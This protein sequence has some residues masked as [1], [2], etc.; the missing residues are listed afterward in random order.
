MLAQARPTMLAFR[1]VIIVI[2]SLDP[3]VF[4]SLECG[5]ARR[6]DVIIIRD[7]DIR[8]V[9]ILRVMVGVFTLKSMGITRFL[10]HAQRAIL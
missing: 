8:S 2:I 10:T 3:F 7:V 5:P 9:I 4:K 1:L 6:R